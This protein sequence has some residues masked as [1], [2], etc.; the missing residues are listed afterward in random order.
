MITFLALMG[1]TFGILSMYLI[2]SLLA[3]RSF[4]ED[5]LIDLDHAQEKIEAIEMANKQFRQE[6]GELKERF[7]L[8]KTK[9]QE[10][11]NL[12]TVQNH[13][14]RGVLYDRQNDTIVMAD[15]LERIGDL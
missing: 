12:L 7:I 13:Y 4:T 14:F 2:K 5:I 8:E 11:T 6:Y 1:L 9:S 15:N 3:E 10:L